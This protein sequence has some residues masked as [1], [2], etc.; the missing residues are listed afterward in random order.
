MK[1]LENLCF[2]EEKLISSIQK[3]RDSGSANFDIKKELFKSLNPLRDLQ[4]FYCDTYEN[5]SR[6]DSGIE[7]RLDITNNIIQALGDTNKEQKESPGLLS[8]IVKDCLSLKS[9]KSSFL[10]GTFEYIESPLQQ[11]KR[12]GLGML[13]MGLGSLGFS[14]PVSEPTKPDPSKHSTIVIF[15]YGGV[16][17]KEIGQIYDAVEAHDRQKSNI[18]GKRKIVVMSNKIV[19]NEDMFLSL[20]S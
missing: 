5:A 2:L 7:A 10:L 11:M 6:A 4:Q 12:A 1:Y 3:H 17:Y 19:N 14:T 16:S 8:R 9:D 18:K 15:V 13:N 20:F